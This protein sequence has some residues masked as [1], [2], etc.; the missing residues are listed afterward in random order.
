[1][2]ATIRGAPGSRKA[3]VGGHAAGR[4]GGVVNVAV[5]AGTVVPVADLCAILCEVDGREVEGG[6]LD[7]VGVLLDYAVDLIG[8]GLGHG[9][10]GSCDEG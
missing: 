6:L 2:L 7:G 5:F 10:E 8:C 4:E 1:M 3:G 9:H